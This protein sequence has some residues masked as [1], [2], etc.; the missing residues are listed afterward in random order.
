MLFLIICYFYKLID[1]LNNL[2]NSNSD[3]N[4]LINSNNK[5]I[6]LYTK[7]GDKGITK[8]FSSGGKAYKNIPKDSKHSELLGTIDLLNSN[9]GFMVETYKTRLK[10]N[11]IFNDIMIIQTILIDTGSYISSFGRIDIN[12]DI[13]VDNIEKNTDE[14]N[15]KL[16]KLTQ[17][18]IPNNQVHIC[19]CL[20]RECERKIHSYFNEIKSKINLH[21][22]IQLLHAQNF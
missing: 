6:K 20:A 10:N 18:I 11:K 17:F 19:R 7:T 14:L 13:Y 21:F 22:S 4:K 8:S 5:K 3:N 15:N 2:I 1:K 9:I 12:Y 16:S